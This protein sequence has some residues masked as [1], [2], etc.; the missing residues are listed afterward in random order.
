MDKFYVR[1]YL[2]LFWAFLVGKFSHICF[3]VIDSLLYIFTITV[4]PIITFTIRLIV[5]II[6]ITIISSWNIFTQTFP[7]GRQSSKELLD[8]ES[9]IRHN[10]SFRVK[11][12]KKKEKK[13]A[14]DKKKKT[15]KT[16]QRGKKTKNIWKNRSRS[17][18][19]HTF[20]HILRA[21]CNC[22]RRKQE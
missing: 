12:K 11:A 14:T 6:I 8:K 5:I 9:E 15:K 18:Q 2:F 17:R 3:I 16:Q 10:F 13:N 20:V 7:R 21:Y 4:I 19:I 1:F 22:T